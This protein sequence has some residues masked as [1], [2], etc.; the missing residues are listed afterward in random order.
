MKSKVLIVA[1]SLLLSACATQPAH[2]LPP[3]DAGIAEQQQAQREAVLRTRR[4]WSLSGRIALSN[5][6][7][8]GSGRIEWEQGADGLQV[9]LS[10]PVT[11]QSWRLSVDAG[12]ARLDGLEGGTRIGPDATVLLREATGWEIPVGALGDWLRGMRASGAA[13]ASAQYDASGR[14]SRLEQDGWVIDYRW[15][16]SGATEPVLPVRIDAAKGEAKVKLIVDDWQAASQSLLPAATGLDM[17]STASLRRALA[18]LNLAD[19]TA[20]LRAHLAQGDARAIGVCGFACL[21][22]GL[23]GE[24][25]GAGE[26]RILDHTGDVLEGDDHLHLKR[27][28]N[29]YARTYN[30]ALRQWRR[31]P[32]A[33]PSRATGT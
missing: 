12:G 14:L 29:H 28:A 10:A 4:T 15:P 9:S 27:A 32:G 31:G 21:A 17:S 6:R 3:Q 25:V 11:R 22:P 16:A 2:R 23:E 30:L 7:N 24:S 8:G 1:A 13:S 26:L 19:P 33:G 5:G 20:D 18:P